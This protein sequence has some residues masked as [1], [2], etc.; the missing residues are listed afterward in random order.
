MFK[1]AAHRGLMNRLVTQHGVN[2]GLAYALASAC[3]PNKRDEIPIEPRMAPKAVAKR[4]EAWE[5]TKQPPAEKDGA[6]DA[7]E[8]ELS[9]AERI[10]GESG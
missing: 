6:S 7:H 3:Y 2:E 8:A 9:D 4:L 10:F 5:R 1:K